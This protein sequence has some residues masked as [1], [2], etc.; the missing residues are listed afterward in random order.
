[1]MNDTIVFVKEINK[2]FDIKAAPITWEQFPLQSKL[3]ER[4][5]SCLQQ[6]IDL[7]DD[8]PG[9][10]QMLAEL[11]ALAQTQAAM[12]NLAC[13][14]LAPALA[15][16]KAVEDVLLK[17]AIKARQALEEK[18]KKG[19]SERFTGLVGLAAQLPRLPVDSLVDQTAVANQKAI[20]QERSARSRT[21]LGLRLAGLTAVLLLLV[22]GVIYLSLIRLPIWG[23]RL[24][25]VGA[26]LPTYTPTPTPIVPTIMPVT[27]T[28]PPVEPTPLPLPIATSI[29][30]FST[31]P[32]DFISPK[33]PSGVHPLYVIDET[34]AKVQ[35]TTEMSIA[36][37]GVG[38]THYSWVSAPPE[39]PV[40][41]TYEFDRPVPT[42]GWYE[43]WMIDAYDGG[44]N[45][46][47]S[48]A[49]VA[50]GQTIN[51]ARG[52]VQTEMTAV[53]Q[54][55]G[56]DEWTSL[57]VYSLPADQPL[58][59]TLTGTT[60]A[61]PTVLGIDALVIAPLYR[62]ALSTHP[63]F[64][65]YFSDKLVLAQLEDGEITQLTPKEG[66][67]VDPSAAGSWNGD[68]YFTFSGVAPGP[69]KAEYKLN[70]P[71]WAG[72]YKLWAWLP[73][74]C[75]VPLTFNVPNVAGMTF[76]PT[77]NGPLN[78]AERGLQGTLQEIGVLTVEK[79]N[80]RPEIKIEVTTE[81][82][83]SGSL[84]LDDLFL[85]IEP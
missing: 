25:G 49:V 58:T 65:Q 11:I 60:L 64:T 1:M 19:R 23:Y 41:A 33:F 27:S 28:P 8:A 78:P 50:G 20:D 32:F 57:G 62:P 7:P 48:M 69:A 6:L 16:K 70:H 12:K 37:G 4:L 46:A 43:F 36:E 18:T 2:L 61:A 67:M 54:K 76:T 84:V 39:T 74:N 30:K 52:G 34:F 14:Q 71:L 75:D 35:Y 72:N 81:T 40:T 82:L 5:Q 79:D 3:Q 45:S 66:W 17:L 73:V 42:G 21:I 63:A 85:T 38:G 26:L 10:P 24:P 59:V 68:T 51:P 9:F 55:S 80:P 77:L 83:Q 44:G 29:S 31:L 22:F 15:E 53:I 56:G 13:G 47:L